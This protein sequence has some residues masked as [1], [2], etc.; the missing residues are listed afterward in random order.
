MYNDRQ[1]EMF[2]EDIKQFIAQ[3]Y[4]WPK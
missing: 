2:P 3:E 4:A 1:G